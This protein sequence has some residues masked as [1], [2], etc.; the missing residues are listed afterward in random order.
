MVTK[1]A[2]LDVAEP[3]A[4]YSSNVGLFPLPALVLAKARQWCRALQRQIRATWWAAVET[5]THLA[6]DGAVHDEA[7]AVMVEAGLSVAA[8]QV[9]YEIF[10]G[11]YP[12]SSPHD[13]TPSAFEAYSYSD[14]E[15]QAVSGL[16]LIRNGEMHADSIV[17]PD[18]QRVVGVTFDDGTR[19]Y[20]VFPHW[21]VY[22]ALPTEVRDAHHPPPKKQLNTL[23]KLKTNQ[24]HHTHYQQ[25]VGGRPVIEVLLDAL[26]FFSRC[27]PRI[28]RVNGDGSPLHF[29]L[30]P[31]SERDYERRHP[32]WKRRELLETELRDLCESNPPGGLRRVCIAYL[33]DGGGDVVA[34]CGYTQLGPGSW[35]MFTETPDQVLRDVVEFGYEYWAE[36]DGT[37]S[38]V[39][40]NEDGTL[41]V[42]NSV[43]EPSALRSQEE[44]PWL[45]WFQISRHDAFAY[46]NQRRP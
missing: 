46:R 26:A 3:F 27:D 33:Q 43:S 31:I 4:G 28:V 14:P 7:E 9:L 34:H 36:L 25:A 18:V 37:A 38:P 19:G 16:K 41:I 23:G 12:R 20:R 39:A 22:S 32:D 45:E 15:G 2:G 13:P 11:A 17:V 10:L 8:I 21:A 44:R 35:S 1:P 5:D 30:E 6:P 24:T 42:D 40:V 29:P